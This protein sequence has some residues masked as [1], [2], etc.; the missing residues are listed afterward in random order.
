MRCWAALNEWPAA[1]FKTAV[2]AQLEAGRSA[3]GGYGSAPGKQDGTLYNA[4]LTLGAYQ[5][6]GME[7]P[8]PEAL[9][10]SLD[11]LRTKDGGF[12]NALSSRLKVRGQIVRRGQLH[13]RKS[14]GESIA[15]VDAASGGVSRASGSRPSHRQKGDWVSRSAG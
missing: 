10:T 15:A 1:D 7:L 3:D 12:A 14:H 5:D 13:R 2:A 6:M 4:F 11:R 9:D 8:D